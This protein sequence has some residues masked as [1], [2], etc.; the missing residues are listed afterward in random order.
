MEFSN[1]YELEYALKE[2]MRLA[3]NA[4]RQRAFDELNINQRFTTD[5]DC[6]VSP[7]TGLPTVHLLGQVMVLNYQ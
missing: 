3:M 2:K 6:M 7:H 5:L 4:T 1:W